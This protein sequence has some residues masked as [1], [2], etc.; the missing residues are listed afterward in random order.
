MINK[1]YNNTLSKLGFKYDD[2]VHNGGS[3][4]T[5]WFSHKENNS[6]ILIE[7]FGSEYDYFYNPNYKTLGY[8]RFNSFK[9]LLNFIK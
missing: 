7:D 2:T 6:M 5:H 4:Y 8:H 3:L 1:N 9:E